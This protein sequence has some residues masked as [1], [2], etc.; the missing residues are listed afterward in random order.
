ML[1]YKEGTENELKGMYAIYFGVLNLS[2][3]IEACWFWLASVLN[4]T[5][6]KSTGYVLEL[7]LMICGDLLK[8]RI[9][10]KFTKLLNYI[11]NYFLKEILNPPVEVRILQL[12]EKLK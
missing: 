7:F 2:C 9:P 12:I 4:T 3:N 8:E 1:I 6:D 5:P 11:K 10:K